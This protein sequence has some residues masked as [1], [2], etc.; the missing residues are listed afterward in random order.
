MKRVVF[1]RMTSMLGRISTPLMNVLRSGH[2]LRNVL[3]LGG[4]T[5]LAQGIIALFSPILSRLY[6]PADFGVFSVY[7]SILAML[8]VVAALRYELAI[9]LPDSEDT[10]A[11]LIT[12]SIMIV[13]GMSALTFIATNA[14]H[15][16]ILEWT[17]S[18]SLEPY[19]GLLALGLAVTGVYQVISYWAV[20]KKSFGHLSRARVG[21]SLG[22]VLT[23]LGLGALRFGSLGLILGNLSGQMVTDIF[24]SGLMLSRERRTLRRVNWDSIRRAANRYR[25][26]PLLSSTSGLLNSTGTN[27]PI[28]LLGALYGPEVVGWLALGRRVVAVPSIL[29]GGAVSQVYLGEASRLAREDCLALYRLFLVTA[30]RLALVGGLPIMLLGLVGPR[31]FVLVFGEA[32]REAGLYVLILAPM[33]A[34]RF[35]ASPLSSTLNVLERQELVLAWDVG[36]T[37]SAVGSILLAKS[38]G[39]PDVKA[40]GFYGASTAVAYVGLFALSTYALYR[41]SHEGGRE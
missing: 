2:F 28:I 9:P 38:F 30:R 34:V 32:W 24:L 17:N 27:L 5:A 7:A 15:D 25:R 11:S 40:I 33:F 8:T 35:V 6:S 29:I 39:W 22:Q 13:I 12:L 18:P 10:A 16:Q 21:Q 14:L 41:A 3:V 31:I 19:L 20:R 1:P 37:L 4:G 36:R 26:F 23:Q